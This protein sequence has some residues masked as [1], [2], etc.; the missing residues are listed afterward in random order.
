MD[1]EWAC[2]ATRGRL[3]Q[4]EGAVTGKDLAAREVLHVKLFCLPSVD[5]VT[6]TVTDTSEEEQ[7]I[8]EIIVHNP[9]CES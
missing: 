7:P 4:T 6:A 8:R 1:R 5:R 9:I 3:F 2:W